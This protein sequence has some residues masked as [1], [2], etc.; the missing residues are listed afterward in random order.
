[1]LS[2]KVSTAGY[3][4]DLTGRGTQNEKGRVCKTLFGGSIPSRASTPSKMWS[5]KYPEAFLTAHQSGP[6]GTLFTPFYPDFLPNRLFHGHWVRR[7]PQAL[8]HD[9]RSVDTVSKE[10]PDRNLTL[11]LLARHASASSA[12]GD[13]LF[14]NFFSYV[15]IAAWID[16]MSI[17]VRAIAAT[18]FVRRS[19]SCSVRIRLIAI[20]LQEEC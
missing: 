7:R 5:T 16:N 4:V 9:S 1:M 6:I 2:P 8:G 18:P 11:R 17:G 15:S 10:S 13:G 19:I 20:S 14:G 3:L 12:E